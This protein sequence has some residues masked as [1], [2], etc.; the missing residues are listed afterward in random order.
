MGFREVSVNEIRE[1]LRGWQ[2]GVGL[3][4]VAERA[5][6]DRKTARR[7]V[8]AAQEAGLERSASVTAITDEIVGAVVAA[9]RPARPNGHGSAW[10]SLLEREAQIKVWV[11]GDGRDHPALSIVKIEELLARSGCMVPYRTLHRFATERCGYR[12]RAVTVRVNDGE[13]GAELQL[14]FGQMGFITDADTGKRRKVHA[15]IFTA[16]YSR[17]MF[18]WLSYSQTLAAVIAGCEAAWVFFNGVFKVL[19]PDNLKPVVTAAD[20]V[21]PKLSSGWLDY[22]Q[23]AG[24]VTDPARVRAPKD[25]SKVERA[26][27]YVRGN[28]WAGESFD[29]L[30]QAQAA[31][32]R[33]CADRA[34]MRVHGSTQARPA[35]VFAQAEAPVLLPV[36]AVYDVPVF[37]RVRVH[38]DLHVEVGKALYSVPGSYLGR[39]LDARADRALVKLYDS[40]RLVRIHPCQ[41][42]GGRSTDPADIPT[43][44]AG[45]ALRD[46]DL[47]V[48]TAA[49]HGPSI[50]AYAAQILDD[51]RPWA[52]MRAVYRL[53]GLVRRYGADPVETAC[54]RALELDVVSV[55]KIE[56]ML[57]RATENTIPLLPGRTD[58]N[59][60]R[61]ARAPA[62]YAARR[63]SEL[64][65]SG[66]SLAS[67]GTTLASSGTILATEGTA[68]QA[69]KRTLSAASV[70]ANASAVRASNATG[71]TVVNP[72]LFTLIVPNTDKE[73]F[74]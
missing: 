45:Y 37:T 14:D 69:A 58:T 27:Q 36:P 55:M 63:R 73:N 11:A 72:G 16:A 35:E 20:P 24:F 3:R 9:V 17:H 52:R 74:L 5:G 28:F 25:K 19:I 48:A 8:L 49:G 29:T 44:K 4:V 50:G 13:P 61:F 71:L 43:G 39:D 66:T 22:A 34:G 42:P 1:V 21:N 40:G 38:R 62:E 60:A 6:V 30:E 64:A 47:L 57:Q 59:G 12:L 56:S 67:G 10:E 65:S 54:A 23:H 18:V 26:V 15:L 2:G 51:P 68:S 70:T 33:W 31:V 32:T 46:L 41:E 53:L 7:Y